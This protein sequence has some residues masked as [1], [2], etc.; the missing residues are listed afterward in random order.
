MKIL[1]VDDDADLLAVTSFALQQAGFLVVK[2]SDG[3]AALDAF[4]REQPHIAVLDINMPRMSGFEL[5]LK[6]R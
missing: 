4:E 1:L 2:A 3:M 6:L 5:A